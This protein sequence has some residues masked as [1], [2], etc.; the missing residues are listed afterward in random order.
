MLCFANRRLMSFSWCDF[1]YSYFQ[2]AWIGISYLVRGFLFFQSLT[3]FL[4]GL[5]RRI[6]HFVESFQGL[7]HHDLENPEEEDRLQWYH[8]SSKRSWIYHESFNPFTGPTTY[9]DLTKLGF[10]S[11]IM[12]L[13]SCSLDLFTEVGSCRKQ[14][15]GQCCVPIKISLQKT[16]H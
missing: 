6:H 12:T 7:G 16:S 8:H 14:V 13:K 9:I 5:K 1:H 2:S 11:D 3:R 10:R 4:Y 15:T